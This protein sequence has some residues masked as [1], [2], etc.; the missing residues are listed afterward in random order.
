MSSGVGGVSKPR[1]AQSWGFDRVKR[2]VSSQCDVDGWEKHKT[3]NNNYQ[4][5]MGVVNTNTFQE[6]EKSDQKN[7][8]SL[9]KIKKKFGRMPCRKEN[10]NLFKHFSLSA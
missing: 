9:K 8:S 2:G 7:N 10:T 6:T 3:T 5:P 4:G 1:V